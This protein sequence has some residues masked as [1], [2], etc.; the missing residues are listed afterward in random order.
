[1][2]FRNSI[3]LNGYL[4][5]GTYQAISNGLYY[6]IIPMMVTNQ[7]NQ[8]K[9]PES[10]QE[11]EPFQEIELFTNDVWYDIESNGKGDFFDGWDDGPIL[12]RSSEDLHFS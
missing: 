10:F 2:S 7:V 12:T 11:Q 5:P 1:M 3:C 9:C 4:A 6:E 8:V